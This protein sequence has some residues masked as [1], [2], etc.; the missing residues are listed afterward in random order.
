M[1]SCFLLLPILLVPSSHSEN[2]VSDISPNSFDAY[3][4]AKQF[5]NYCIVTS[6]KKIQNSSVI[7]FVLRLCLSQGVPLL[8]QKSSVKCVFLCLIEVM[9]LFVCLFVFRLF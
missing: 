4:Q 8:C 6:T 3:H 1:T 5:Q 2:L 7:R 9:F